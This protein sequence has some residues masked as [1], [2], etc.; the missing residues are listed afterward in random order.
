[1]SE[2]IFEPHDDFGTILPVINRDDFTCSDAAV[3]FG[4][5]LLSENPDYIAVEVHQGGVRLTTIKQVRGVQVASTQLH[6]LKK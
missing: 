1:M 3:A 5:E 6:P 4:K 2:F